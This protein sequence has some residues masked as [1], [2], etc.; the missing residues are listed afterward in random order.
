MSV[1]SF[2]RLVNEDYN[3]LGAKIIGLFPSESLA[4]H[5]CPPIRKANHPL[6]KS[7][8]AKGKLV[9][10]VRNI[11][12]KSGDTAIKRETKCNK[13]PDNIGPNISTSNEISNGKCK[14]F[15]I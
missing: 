5:Y 11:L 7:V 3:L 15:K 6:K 9:N 10:Q 8:M 2:S 12:F 14:V 4:M 13:I 1:L